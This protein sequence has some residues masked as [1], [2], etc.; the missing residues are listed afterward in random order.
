MM[1]STNDWNYMKAIPAFKKIAHDP[2]SEP[3]STYGLPYYVIIAAMLAKKKMNLVTNEYDFKIENG[4]LVR[5]LGPS[6]Y[7][8]SKMNLGTQPRPVFRPWVEYAKTALPIVMKDLKSAQIDYAA[9][10]NKIEAV[11]TANQSTEGALSSTAVH[12]EGLKKIP[13]N[14]N[15]D[16][17][18]YYNE[19]MGFH[20]ELKQTGG[21]TEI[22]TGMDLKTGKVNTTIVNH[23]IVDDAGYAKF[24]NF[25][26]VR[27]TDLETYALQL[28]PKLQG[29]THAAND[30]KFKN[31]IK[32]LEKDIDDFY[33]KH[34]KSSI[35]LLKGANQLQQVI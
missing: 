19:S 16:E 35:D 26:T 18:F 29:S 33:N 28:I 32:A 22:S 3:Y 31:D 10:V 6:V 21:S 8:G 30:T 34:C 9:L 15:P 12:E 2:I 20:L 13:F 1:T 11:A 25:I 23:A 14:T 17:S 24:V 27:K 7:S 5:V 4:H